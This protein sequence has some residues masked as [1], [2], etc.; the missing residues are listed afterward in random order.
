MKFQITL[1]SVRITA[2]TCFIQGH[3]RG[4]VTIVVSQS[5]QPVKLQIQVPGGC[6]CLMRGTGQTRA[7]FVV[8]ICF[9]CYFCAQ[10]SQP[11]KEVGIVCSVFVV[12][13]GGGRGKEGIFQPGGFVKTEKRA[14]H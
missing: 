8:S 14:T 10:I 12:G 2:P 4:S 3:R 11:E 9:L 7:F 13:G 1:F 5:E 6:L